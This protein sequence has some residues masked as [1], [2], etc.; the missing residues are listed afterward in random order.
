MQL[1]VSIAASVRAVLAKD[2][3]TLTTAYTVGDVRLL[4]GAWATVPVCCAK[5]MVL[6]VGRE[7]CEQATCKKGAWTPVTLLCI[8]RV[9]YVVTEVSGGVLKQITGLIEQPSTW[10]TAGVVVG[11]LIASIVTTAALWL[12]KFRN[13]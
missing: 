12:W 3:V 10:I 9:P 7:S 1:E 13:R 4:A 8:P 11:L 6:P 2:N 5:G